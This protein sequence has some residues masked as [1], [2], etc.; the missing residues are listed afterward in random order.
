MKKMTVFGIPMEV[1]STEELTEAA[2]T[3]PGPTYYAVSRVD[4]LPEDL[5]PLFLRKRNLR[6]P[7]EQCR[8]ICWYDPKNFIPFTT[9]ICM[10]CLAAKS[11][12]GQQ[13]DVTAKM[14]QINEIRR[15]GE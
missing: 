14:A 4:D 10:Q 11:E 2:R 5:L 7:C 8:A 6:T 3:N 13:I 12:A 1:G 15:H 9:V